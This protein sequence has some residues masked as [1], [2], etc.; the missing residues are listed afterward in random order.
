MKNMKVLLGS[1]LLGSALAM[2]GCAVYPEYNYGYGPPPYAPAHGYRYNYYGRDLVYDSALGVY[3]VI[4]VTDYYFLDNYYYRYTPNGWFYSR[5]FDRDWRPYQSDK[6][7]P[8]LV[9][10]YHGHEGV[11]GGH[12]QGHD[13]GNDRGGGHDQGDNR[14]GGHD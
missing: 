4:G 7:P 6:L 3:I 11:R 1:V 13:Q 12:N 14:G 2:T 9:R 5:E 10:K 8:G